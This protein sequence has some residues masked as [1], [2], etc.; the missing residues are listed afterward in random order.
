MKKAIIMAGAILAT[1]YLFSHG[2]FQLPKPLPVV[3]PEV[4]YQELVVEKA[5]N[6]VVASEVF[7]KDNK[8]V[9]T[10]TTSTFEPYF[11]AVNRSIKLQFYIMNTVSPPACISIEMH[12]LMVKMPL[13]D[14]TGVENENV[15]DVK[16]VYGMA[17]KKYQAD[18][19]KFY[20]E[21]RKAFN[22]FCVR[23]QNSLL[24]E[25]KHLALHSNLAGAMNLANKTLSFWHEPA[26]N[27][28][29][30]N[31]TGIDV[32]RMRPL[33]LACQGTVILVNTR[34]GTENDLQ[35][36]VSVNLASMA[37]AI[38]YTLQ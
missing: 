35:N 17:L 5:I 14:M 33:P 2:P 28:V 27:F 25:N 21:R 11:K 24:L 29:L 23:V 18:S 9:E 37:Q 10:I 20:S 15:N 32:R 8:G 7:E 12:A 26:A 6:V 3:V 19:M 1:F 38:E 22:D 30:F 13:I 16:R 4:R 31:S 36:I 34:R